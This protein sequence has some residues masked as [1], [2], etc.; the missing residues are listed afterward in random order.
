MSVGDGMHVAQLRGYRRAWNYG[1]EVLRGDW[2]TDDGTEVIGGL[3]VSLG[4][5]AD[6]DE[7]INGV[8]FAVDDRELADLDWRER[9]YERV[10]VTE[11]VLLMDAPAGDTGRRPVGVYVPRPHSIARY[12]RH[13]DAGTAGI[14]RSY[15]ELVDAAFEELGADHADWY[16]RTRAP[17]VPVVDIT[18]DPLPPRRPQAR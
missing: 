5:V 7:A 12:E 17:D 11:Q 1:S 3:V 4:L 15:W 10:D 13:R 8:L 18:P 9:A 14:R 16:R 2:I 6:A